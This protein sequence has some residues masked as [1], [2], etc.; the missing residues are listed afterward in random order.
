MDIT[1]YPKLYEAL[2]I[3]LEE[4][5]AE[6]GFKA[7][8]KTYSPDSPQYPLIVFSEV[9]NQPKTH[10]YSRREQI[11]S[12]GY[13][14][15]IYAKTSVIT[16]PD[17]KKVTLNKQEI[18]RQL[19]EFITNFMQFKV[20]MDLISNNFDDKAGTQGELYKQIL[21]FQKS[22]NNNREYFF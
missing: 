20:G 22:H 10:I 1:V 2:E 11:Y 18:C 19:M 14:F 12:L 21:V 16:L 15:D 6:T 4:F 17:K 9:R 8:I 7:Q 13:K 5:N 3:A